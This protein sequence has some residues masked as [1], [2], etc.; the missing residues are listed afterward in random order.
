M[1]PEYSWFHPLG[2][3]STGIHGASVGAGSCGISGYRAIYTVDGEQ[4]II[5]VLDVGT[6]GGIYK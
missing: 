5:L 1:L 6:R 3:Q 2:D 4:L